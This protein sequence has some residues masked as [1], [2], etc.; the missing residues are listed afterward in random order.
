MLSERALYTIV[1]CG[2]DCKE[3]GV[4]QWKLGTEYL[5]ID[6]MLSCR[7]TNNCIKAGQ[8]TISC[9]LHLH[10]HNYGLFPNIKEEQQAAKISDSREMATSSTDRMAQTP[11]ILLFTY[12]MC[13]IRAIPTI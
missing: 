5:A 9:Y 6:T 10:V 12:I 7:Y 4:Q 8:L 2:D 3:Y 1:K 13:N 11:P